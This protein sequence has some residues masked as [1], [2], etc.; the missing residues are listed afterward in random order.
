LPRL[1]RLQSGAL[2]RPRS[3]EYA[4]YS[5]SLR[6]CIACFFAGRSLAGDCPDRP[7]TG[8][9]ELL[10]GWASGL[11]LRSPLYARVARE[12]AGDPHV[13]SIFGED[14]DWR[15]PLQLFAG[16]HYLVLC[17]RASWDDVGAAVA[18]HADFLRDR[19]A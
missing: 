3:S 19:V 11:E 14:P 16:V 10:L 7:V 2:R 18:E 4:S 1:R 12:L 8:S 13:D 17:G 6:P 5:D 15:A 9:T